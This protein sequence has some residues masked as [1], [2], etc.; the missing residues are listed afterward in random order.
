L[1]ANRMGCEINYEQGTWIDL[2]GSL[3]DGDIDV[4]LG[5]S[6]TPAREEFAFFSD[7]YRMEEF[8]LYIRNGEQEEFDYD[9]LT[10]F[11]KNGG[12]VGVVAEYLYGDEVAS[13]V[14]DPDTSK[15]FVNAIMGELNVARLMDGDIDGFLED[16]FVGASLLRR[17]A[18]SDYI[19]AQGISIETGNAY[20]MFSQKSITPEQLAAFNAELKRVK[21]SPVYEDLIKKYSY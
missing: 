16:S 11:V 2:L 6:K 20:V 17:K 1:V 18:L 9:T 3:K 14:D 7:P 5:A 12:K 13:L 21:A 19:I 8:A 10:E 4:L 15:M